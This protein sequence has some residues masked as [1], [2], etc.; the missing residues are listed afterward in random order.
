MYQDRS[1]FGGQRGFAPVN[2]GQEIDVKI[3]AVG[4]KGD[5]I[6]KEKGF[7]LFVP[8]AK[9]GD[10]VRIKITK[11]LRNVGFAEVV[12]KAEGIVGEEKEEEPQNTEDFGE[13]PKEE[14][15]DVSKEE[16]KEESS[17][18]EPAEEESKDT[19]DFGEEAEE[20]KKED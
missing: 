8:G 19:E 9:E 18:A 10:E 12:G 7:V 1:G 3:D 6:A 13:E 16:P 15:S 2:V 14:S 11:V 20:D 5:G 4:E 17:D